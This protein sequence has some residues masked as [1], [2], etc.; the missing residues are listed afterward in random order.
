[1]I[2]IRRLVKHLVFA[3]TYSVFGSAIVLIGFYVYM[4]EGRPDL[5]IWHLA[6]LDTEFQAK[7]TANITVSW[8]IGGAEATS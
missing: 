4:L 2:F 6:E 3:V 7:Q 5:K 8:S 1:M